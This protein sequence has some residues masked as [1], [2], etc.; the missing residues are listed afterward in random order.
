[1]VIGAVIAF[2]YTRTGTGG[3]YNAGWAVVRVLAILAL[4][5]AV[6]AALRIAARPRGSWSR[7][8]RAIVLV[9][10]AA[11]IAALLVLACWGLFAVAW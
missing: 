2:A 3:V 4:T 7:A 11:S 6:T 5:S 9:R 8:E 10:S 1:M